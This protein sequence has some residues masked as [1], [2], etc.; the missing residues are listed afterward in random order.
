[1]ELVLTATDRPSRRDTA[2]LVLPRRLHM[3]LRIF[4]LVFVVSFALT[5]ERMISWHVRPL[6]ALG[7][8]AVGLLIGIILA[9]SKPLTW[10]DAARQVATGSTAIGVA[11]ML[12][13]LIFT[14]Q[15]TEILD[16]WIDDVQ[17]AGIVA[18]A[19]TS[20][21]MC[22]RLLATIRGV[23][24]LLATAALTSDAPAD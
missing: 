21:V 24:G 20:G 11:L 9:R 10:D 8:L 1:M 4:A 22:G 2:N 7:G 18:I 17:I 6:W 3:Q 16:R 23:R 12:L 13:Y 19:M 15:K 5:I 14:L